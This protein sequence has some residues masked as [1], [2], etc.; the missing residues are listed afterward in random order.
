MSIRHAVAAAVLAASFHSA[1][2]TDADDWAVFGRALSLMQGLLQIA[3]E[4]PAADEHRMQR[5]IDSMLSGKNADVNALMGDMFADMPPSVREQLVAVARTAVA[6]SQRQAQSR[7]RDASDAQAIQ[8]RK[9][10]AA[11]GLTY[12]DA[13][14]FLD[15]VRRNDALAARLYLAGRALDVKT[16]E[17]ARALATEPEMRQLF[18]EMA[19]R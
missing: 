3:A 7:S 4:S 19:K 11:M 18:S 14:Q 6:A 10:L 9:D 16:V 12:F 17:Q 8:A 1:H 13:R 2:A 5:A 15:A